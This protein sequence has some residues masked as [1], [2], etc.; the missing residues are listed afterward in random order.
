MEFS[1]DIEIAL[2]RDRVIELF[3][4]PDNM[5]K[6]Q[7]DLVSFET[8]EGARGQVGAKSRLI[9]KIKGREVVM[10]ETITK[11]EIPDEPSGTY[12]MEGIFNTLEN[13]FE[14]IAPGRTVWKSKSTFKFSGSMKMMA[15]FM[16]ST[17]VDHTRKLMQNFK[18]FAEGQE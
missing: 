7:P 5:K 6:W 10:I 9:Y 18:E 14:E 2:P 3:D 13:H 12:E 11:R 15:M 1:L 8:I 17:F 16:K 4:N